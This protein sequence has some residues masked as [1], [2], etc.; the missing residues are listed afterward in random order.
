MYVRAVTIAA[1]HAASS[2]SAKPAIVFSRGSSMLLPEYATAPLAT[3]TM[4]LASATSVH[5]TASPASP[6]QSALHAAL[7]ESS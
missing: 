6:Q 7:R 4:A 5:S 3:M 1:R 2:T